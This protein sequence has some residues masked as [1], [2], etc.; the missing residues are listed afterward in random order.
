MS[1]FVTMQ[2]IKVKNK[3]MDPTILKAVRDGNLDLQLIN[4]TTSPTSYLYQQTYNYLTFPNTP[5][6]FDELLKPQLVK[7]N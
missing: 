5:E 2:A 3:I 7:K 4:M 6:E 1:E